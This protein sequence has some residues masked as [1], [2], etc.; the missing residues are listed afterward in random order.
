MLDHIIALTCRTVVSGEQA[1]IRMSVDRD[2]W[3]S[4]DE[5]EQE[6]LRSMARRELWHAVAKRTGRELTE[7]EL[8]ALPVWVEYPDR[9]AV[10]FV[11]GPHDGQRVQFDRPE[12]PAAVVMALPVQPSVA[13]LLSSEGPGVSH[14][15]FP[16]IQY[17]PLLDEHG[18]LARARDG[19]WRYRPC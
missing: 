8:A 2:L 16:R 4:F 19:A 15:L 10:E 1:W 13:E 3:D 12:P 7:A 5:F 14:D 17:V 9:S 6:R 18:F 11:G